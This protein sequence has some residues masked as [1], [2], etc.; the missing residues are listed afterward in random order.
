MILLVLTVRAHRKKI[1]NM[2][3]PA[4]VHCSAGVGRTGAFIA[5][6]QAIDA[7]KQRVKVDINDVVVNMRQCRM[8]LIQHTTQYSF[9]WAAARD[10]I[11]GKLELK[12]AK[13]R[14]QPAAPTAGGGQSPDRLHNAKI[15]DLFRVIENFDNPDGNEGVLL[16]R[17]GDIVELVETS[18]LWWWM[19]REYEEGWVLPDVIEPIQ[20][21]SGK[22]AP[23]DP[24]LKPRLVTDDGEQVPNGSKPAI[25]QKP[26]VPGNKPALAAKPN[27]NPFAAGDGPVDRT[28]SANNPFE[29]CPFVDLV[30]WHVCVD[31]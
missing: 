3:S 14:T 31:I 28:A 26:T 1:D 27:V 17:A 20:P 19:R 2:A 22:P 23:P 30:V 4:I 12:A 16:V 9:V 18:D 7:Y 11:C 10:Y 25:S 15:G 21:A 8:A 13:G 29:V 6:D 5:I 24:A